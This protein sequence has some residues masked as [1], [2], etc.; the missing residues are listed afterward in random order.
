M[1]LR[2][3]DDIA[4]VLIELSARRGRALLLL[5]SVALSTGVLVASYSVSTAAAKQVDTGLVAAGSTTFTVSARATDQDGAER[6]AVVFPA[7]TEERADNVDLVIAAGRRLDVPRDDAKPRR[8]PN[9]PDVAKVDVVGATSGYLQ[10]DEA[11]TGSAPTWLLDGDH[12]AAVALVGARAAVELG[13][14]DGI[15]PPGVQVWVAGQTYS[16]TGT[17][18]ASLDDNLVDAVVIP[19]SRALTISGVSD[20]QTVVLV[21]TEIGGGAPVAK[22]IRTAIRPDRPQLL[23]TSTVAEFNELRSGVGAQLARLVAT[24]GLLLL[25]VATLLIANS[26][27]VSVVSRTAEIGLRRSMGASQRD[28]ARIFLIEG[29]LVGALG[30]LL[31]AACGLSA[32]LIVAALSHWDTTQPALAAIVGPGVG[33]LAGIIASAYPSWRAAI[34]LPADAMRAD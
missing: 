26:M 22:V 6:Q 29:G 4:D 30:G 17:I 13:L 34:I 15:P 7:D 2:L 14:P 28:I 9:A 24:I 10:A 25:A 5:V 1:L 12:S 16:V 3:R 19:H 20:A 31:G 18:T 27:I 33:L 8:L 23:S 11:A 32:A 21:R